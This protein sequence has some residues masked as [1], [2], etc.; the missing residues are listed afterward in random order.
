MQ[1]DIKLWEDFKANK[2]YALS[3]IYINSIELL[4]TYGKKFTNDDELLKDTIQELF[5]DLIRTRENLGITD[6]IRFYLIKSF[7]R[8]LFRELSS[9]KKLFSLDD[10]NIHNENSIKDPVDE[11]CINIEEELINIEN[12]SHKK[13]LILKAVEK[14]SPRL[15]EIIFYR[16]TCDF[17]YDQICDIMLIEYDSARKMVFMAVKSL[18]KYYKEYNYIEKEL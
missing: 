12:Y 6:N 8:K 9:R 11:S 18:K 5:F 17:S 10:S 4:Y 7:K 16:Y 13:K 1:N 15:Q 14:L 2:E 3:Q